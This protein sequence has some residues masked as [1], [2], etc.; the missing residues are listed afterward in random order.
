MEIKG[1]LQE[2][3]ELR[4]ELEDIWRPIRSGENILD[5][6]I[7]LTFFNDLVDFTQMIFAIAELPKRDIS[8][9]FSDFKYLKDPHKN[10]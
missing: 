9:E 7:I 5:L 3:P 4:K 6:E 8:I 1:L 10:D 2:V